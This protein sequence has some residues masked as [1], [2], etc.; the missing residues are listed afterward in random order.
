MT[1]TSYLTASQLAPL[2]KSK[3]LSPV[4]LMRD[5]LKRIKEADSTVNAYITILGEHALAEAKHTENQIQKGYYK[6]P[7]HGIPLGV[8]DNYYTKGIPTT[9]GS[10]ILKDFV[11]TYNA[12]SVD[13][14]LQA[15]AIMTGKLNMHEFGGGLT[16]TNPF[17]GNVR[18]PWNPNHIPGG[19]S[20]GSGAALAAGMAVIATGS[21]TFGSIRVPAAMCGVYGLKPTYG[22]ISSYGIAPLAWSLDHPGPMA[23]SVADLALMLNV[24]T[25]YDPKS[26]ET[27]CVP[28]PDYTENLHRGIRGRKIG[29][30]AFYLKGLDD[31]VHRLFS[32][33]VRK[34][35]ELGAHV[36]EVSIPE[37]ELAAFTGYVVT[38]GEAAS[39][40]Y[41]DLQNRPEDFA[42]DVRAFFTAG[43]VIPAP[44]YIRSQ[45]ARRAL[46]KAFKKVFEEVDILAAPTIP[47]ISPP[48]EE[49]F[50]SQNLSIIERCMP[51]TAPPAAAGLPTLAVPIGFSS[52]GLPSGMQLIAS[53]LDEKLLLQAG[54]AWEQT[55]PLGWKN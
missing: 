27:L 43:T 8:K 38:T 50:V 40:H 47:I 35:E 48:F 14:L 42:A 7:L 3:Q 33:A 30:P 10:K 37:I 9:A 6:G 22:L 11:P 41:E 34:L 25:G 20:G 44:Y 5:V 12:T 13:K 36:T 39:Y 24:M 1:D 26:P 19:S 31:E 2:L 23:R 17:Y 15:G 46:I 55:G 53:H 49:N 52:A 21:D 32:Q 4:E 28:V 16:N 54:Y 18:N 29:I 45:Q 51:F